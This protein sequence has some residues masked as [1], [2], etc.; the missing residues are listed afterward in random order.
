MWNFKHLLCAGVMRV[1]GSW[2][3]VAIS[4][5]EGRKLW[6]GKVHGCIVLRELA[7]LGVSIDTSTV[8]MKY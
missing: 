8:F 6:F 5:D 1:P 7:V 3:R 2:C 4:I